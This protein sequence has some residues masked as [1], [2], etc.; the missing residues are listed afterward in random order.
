MSPDLALTYCRM[1]ADTLETN[2]AGRTIL[3]EGTGINAATLE[4]GE[5][6]IDWPGA[7]RLIANALALSPRPDLALRTG[8]RALP[9]MHGPMGMAA[10]ASATLRDAMLLFARFNNTRTRVFSTHLEEDREAI[11]LRLDFIEPQDYAVRFLTESALASAFACHIVLRGRPIKDGAVHFNYPPPEHAVLYRE[12][13]AGI[14][15]QFDA[16]RVALTLP[17]HYGDEPVPSHDRDLL[18]MAVRQCEA[19]QEALRRH[20][21]FSDQVLARLRAEPEPDLVAVAGTLHVS[22]RTL[23]RRLKAEGT[24]FQALRDRTRAQR[25]AELLGLPHY[26]VAAVARELGYTDVASFRR[27][28]RRW[29]G[30]HPSDFRRS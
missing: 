28:F 24:R 16:P 2:D 17:A 23:I 18:W 9:A 1:I 20:G 4:Q 15:V 26:T 29:Y 21:S 11:T 25:A 13:F 3:L 22:P 27:A 12:A 7:R 14:R 6:F 5:G 8:L 30:T 10:M 19:R